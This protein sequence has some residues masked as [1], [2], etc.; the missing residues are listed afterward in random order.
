MNDCIFCKIISQ[1][2]PSE[3][4]YEDE[5]TLAFLDINP[6]NLGHTLVIPKQHHEN[7]FDVPEEILNNTMK[8]L[9]KVARSVDEISDGINVGQNNRPAAGQIVN[10]IHFHVIPRFE[11]D[12]LRSWP[13]KKYGEAEIKETLGKIRKNLE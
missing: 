8:V 11:K 12:G 1:E 5:N 10:H 4:V 9:Q 2:I 6:I 3:I 13:G 7:I